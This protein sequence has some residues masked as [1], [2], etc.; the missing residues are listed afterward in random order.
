VAKPLA[1]YLNNTVK[2][3]ALIETAVA[4]GVRHFVFSSSAAVYGTPESFP[5]SEDAPLRPESPYGRSKLM[6]EMMLRTP[7]LPTASATP[8]SAISTLPARTRGDG[9]GN[10]PGIRPTWSRSP[11]RPRSGSAP[12]WR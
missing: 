8:R 1:Y 9:R 7:P 11:A 6:T 2:S 12:A 4:G 3:R 5:V 10:R